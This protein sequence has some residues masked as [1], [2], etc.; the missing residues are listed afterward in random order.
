MLISPGPLFVALL[1]P[2]IDP[3][4]KVDRRGRLGLVIG[5]AGVV[6][7]I[8]VDTVHSLG[9]F[10]GALAV[11]GAALAYGLGAMYVAAEVPRRASARGQLRRACAVAA[12]LTLPPALATLGEQQSRRRRDRGGRRARRDRHGGRVRPLLRLI[13]ETGAGRASLVRIPDPADS[14]S[15]TARCCSTRRSRPRRSPAWC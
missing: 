10:L 8:G 3:T 13:A 9:E 1:A 2:L 4:E 5:F 6:L 12:V 11:L 7:L 14:R 15:P